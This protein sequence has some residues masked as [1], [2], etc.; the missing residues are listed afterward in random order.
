MY[1]VPRDAHADILL[2]FLKLDDLA[3]RR[4]AHLVKLIKSFLKGKCHPAMPSLVDVRPDKT[5]TVHQSNSS[6]G[7][8]RPSVFGATFFNQHL[9]YNSDSDDTDT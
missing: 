4:E 7:A 8:R 1:E 6:L 5:L 3:H 9:G 2:L